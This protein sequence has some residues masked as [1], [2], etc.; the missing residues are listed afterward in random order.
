VSAA[1][2]IAILAHSTNPRGGV[3]HA[4]ELGDALTRLG[5][6]VTV[7]GP[8]ASGAGFFRETVCKT[9]CVSAS[10]APRDVRLMAE[11]RIADYLRFFEHAQNRRFDVWHAQD[12]ISG[13]ALATLKQRNLIGAFARTVHHV[14]DFADQRLGALQRRA[15][16]AADRLFAVSRFWRDW[17][18]NE[19]G[20]DAVIVGNGVDLRRFSPHGDDTDAQLRGRLDL[21]SAKPVFLAIGGVEE[22]KNALGML[23]AFARLH[24]KYPQSRLIIAGGA[25]LLDHDAYQVRFAGALAET[26]LP[27]DAVIRTGPLPQ[28]LM[29]ALYRAATAFVFA[30]LREGFGL[31][32]LE[33]MASGLP[34]AVSRIAPFTEYLGDD[35][36][37]WCDPL[38][39]ASIAAAMARSLD[40]AR[41]IGLRARGLAVAARHDWIATARA[42]L[43]TYEELWERVDA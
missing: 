41:R 27:V 17:L 24:G 43:A 21:Q 35:E 37:S 25:S 36:V 23:K 11:M 39:T 3:V 14:D 9:V 34:V 38:D 18:E 15:I 4:I 13:N 2:R 1:P 31:V 29:P 42:H 22:R 7:H 32:V 30:S 12:G 19:L 16:A 26:N 6:D 33:A 28:E 10:P 8:S 5:H 20:R 40:P